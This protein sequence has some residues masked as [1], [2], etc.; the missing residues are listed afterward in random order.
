MLGSGWDS[1]T[2]AVFSNLNYLMEVSAGAEGWKEG[3][4]DWN[5]VLMIPGN[6]T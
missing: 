2:S 4:S 6:E 5:E 1:M 3:Q